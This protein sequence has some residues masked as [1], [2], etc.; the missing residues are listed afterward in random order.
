MNGHF[1]QS[2]WVR[3]TKLNLLGWLCIASYFIGGLAG[4]SL[5]VVFWEREP[6]LISI[7]FVGLVVGWILKRIVSSRER[8]YKEE[9]RAVW[10]DC[11]R[12]LESAGAEREKE[13]EKCMFQCQE[14]ISQ[15]LNPLAAYRKAKRKVS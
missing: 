14:F 4:F 5:L 12:E 11:F 1:D 13:L 8:D 6:E 9:E 2:K 10:D 7:T 3:K 15:G